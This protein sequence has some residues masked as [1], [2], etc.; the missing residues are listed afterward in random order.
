MF[1]AFFFLTSW[2]HD[3]AARS[4]GTMGDEPTAA[5]VAATLPVQQ[6]AAPSL[7]ASSGWEGSG[8]TLPVQQ[9]AKVTL[10]ERKRARR[11]CKNCHA[12]K[13]RCEM[14]STGACASCI[15]KNWLCEQISSKRRTAFRAGAPY[16]AYPAMEM[17]GYPPPGFE[18]QFGPPPGMMHV[19]AGPPGMH[20]GHG[21]IG[22]FSHADPNGSPCVS[23]GPQHSMPHQRMGHH[24]S[25]RPQYVPVIMSADGL[26]HPQ[27]PHIQAYA[28]YPAQPYPPPGQ[29]MHPGHMMYAPQVRATGHVCFAQELH[30]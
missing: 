30:I 27:P 16:S 1:L 18:F 14:T 13:L 9:D 5:P 20:P 25:M 23:Y 19:Q 22:H 15:S 3:C 4:S 21:F 7:S 8:A 29:V 26:P 28:P 12:R 17:V 10:P 2:D 24:P 6:D 11:A